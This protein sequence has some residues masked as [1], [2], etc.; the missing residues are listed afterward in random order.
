MSRCLHLS[1]Q[2]LHIALHIETGFLLMQTPRECYTTM[3]MHYPAA[4][5]NMDCKQYC[6]KLYF[7]PLFVEL[8]YNNNYWY[9]RLSCHSYSDHKRLLVALVRLNLSSLSRKL[10]WYSHSRDLTRSD[11]HSR[12]SCNKSL[13]R[14]TLIFLSFCSNPSLGVECTNIRLDLHLS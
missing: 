3:L 8:N 5:N 1:R 11:C 12:D 13:C 9:Q 4:M 14:T 7:D 6:S 2:K 10:S